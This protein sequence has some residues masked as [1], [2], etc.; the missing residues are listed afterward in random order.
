MHTIGGAAWLETI[1]QA[2]PNAVEDL[3]MEL[4]VLQALTRY[5]VHPVVLRTPQ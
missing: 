2:T 5:Y 4:V 3:C 1:L